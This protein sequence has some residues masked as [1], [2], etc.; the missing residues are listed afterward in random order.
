[1]TKY[2]MAQVAAI[3]NFLGAVLVFVSFQ[4]TST[5][6]LMIA[7]KDQSFAFCIGDRAIFGL[8]PGGRGTYI[9]AAC[10]QGADAK[11]AAV[12]STDYPNLTKFG[13]VLVGV[14]FF[15]QLFSLEKPKLEP[16]PRISYGPRQKSPKLS[17]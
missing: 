4:A 10:P 1:M 11:P 13:W 9:G 2:W 6:L 5:D 16:T 7:N 15:L 8:T 17:N 12:V 3:C 14:G